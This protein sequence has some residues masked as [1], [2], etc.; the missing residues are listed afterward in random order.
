[1]TNDG[2]AA[3]RQREYRIERTEAELHKM[4][5]EM[6]GT[7]PRPKRLRDYAERL[8]ARAQDLRDV[9]DEWEAR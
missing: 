6:R 8:A 1:M 9:A 3:N 2:R 7:S 4:L 5:M